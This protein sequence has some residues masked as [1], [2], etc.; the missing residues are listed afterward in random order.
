[1]P[2]RRWCRRSIAAEKPKPMARATSSH[3]PSVKTLKTAIDAVSSFN[4]DHLQ[5]LIN[6]DKDAAAINALNNFKR[7]LL[8]T[9]A[10]KADALQSQIRQKSERGTPLFTSHSTF[11]NETNA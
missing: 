10:R 8:A 6:K 5:E 2:D 4:T 11:Q 3:Q 7:D 9:A 1:M